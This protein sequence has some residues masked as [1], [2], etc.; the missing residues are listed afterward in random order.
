MSAGKITVPD[1][2]AMMPAKCNMSLWARYSART[3]VQEGKMGTG[4]QGQSAR[5]RASERP[6][7]MDVSFGH[8][9]ACALCAIRT[10][11]LPT[12]C[13]TARALPLTFSRLHQCTVLEAFSFLENYVVSPAR[14][15]TRARSIS[16]EFI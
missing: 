2:S 3:C 1:L 5:A 11:L 15:R 16:V 6:Q 4:A 9:H 8:V 7:R 13:R 12:F 14:A 10:Q